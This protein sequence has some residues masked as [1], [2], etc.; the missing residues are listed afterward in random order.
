MKMPTYSDLVSKGRFI[1]SEVSPSYSTV[2][3]TVY[4]YKGSYYKV[5]E[6]QRLKEYCISKIKEDWIYGREQNRD[7][8]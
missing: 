5:T 4:E 2:R 8:G 1:L 7:I 6:Y 3:N